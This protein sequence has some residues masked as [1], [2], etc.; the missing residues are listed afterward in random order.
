MSSSSLAVALL[1]RM[2]KGEGEKR[3]G[4]RGVYINARAG[5]GPALLRDRRCHALRCHPTFGASSLWW[6]PGTRSVSLLF[7]HVRHGVTARGDSS[8]HEPG[9]HLHTMGLSIPS[10]YKVSLSTRSACLGTGSAVAG[11]DRL[12]KRSLPPARA[13]KQEIIQSSTVGSDCPVGEP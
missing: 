1:G 6:L 8:S 9:R 4:R 10:W 13:A 12:P 2:E 5:S 11:L 7:V 3:Q